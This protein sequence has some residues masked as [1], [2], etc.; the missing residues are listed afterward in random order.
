[1]TLTTLL[2]STL[3]SASP[4]L[5]PASALEVLQEGQHADD[6]IARGRALLDAGEL[7]GALELFEQADAESKGTLSTRMWVLRVWF[8]Q[9]RI[10][11]A[12]NQ[13]DALAENNKGPDLDYLYG[14]GSF[15]K[16]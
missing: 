15:L 3:L 14:M 8:A 7:D 4:T 13:T 11:D 5:A 2:V 9:D 1:M 12:F 6:L 10:N 16:A